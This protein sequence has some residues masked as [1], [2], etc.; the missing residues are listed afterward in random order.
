MWHSVKRFSQPQ[1]VWVL[2]KGFLESPEGLY[3]P[4]AS[5]LL[6]SNTWEG[7]ESIISYREIRKTVQTSGHC[8]NLDGTVT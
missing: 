6:P 3:Q 8:C 4:T 1:K 5:N 7:L 2:I